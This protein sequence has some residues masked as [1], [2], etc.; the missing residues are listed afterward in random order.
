MSQGEGMNIRIVTGL[1]QNSEQR[2]E[3]RKRH[4]EINKAKNNKQ[5]KR[6]QRKEKKTR[7]KITARKNHE[8]YSKEMIDTARRS[9]N[10]KV[11]REKSTK[12]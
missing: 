3:A 12:T 10:R 5:T 6:I 1:T 11:K 7:Q 2:I 4:Q 8:L 9:G